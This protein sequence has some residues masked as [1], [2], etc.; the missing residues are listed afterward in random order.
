MLDKKALRR[1]AQANP[2]PAIPAGHGLLHAPQVEH[3]IRS[4]VRIIGH[5]RTLVLYVY[6]REQA[7]QGD[8][9]PLWTMFHAKDGYIT[10]A[11]NP[12]GTTKWRTATFEHLK[13]DYCFVDK[14][15]FYSAKD[16]ERVSRYFNSDSPGFAS[17]VRAQSKLLDRRLEKR[18]RERDRKVRARM[19]GLPAL[20]RDLGDWLRRAVLPA[21]FLYAHAKGG[22]ATGVCSSCGQE[23]SLTGVKHNA[24]GVCPHCGRE[25]TMKVRG[26]MGRLCDRETCQVVQ[27]TGPDELVIRIIK[28]TSNVSEI[29]IW[30]NARQF[31]SVDPDGR[32]QCDSYYDCCDS[33][34]PHWK[35]GER[36]VFYPYSYNFY[37]DTCGHVYCR[38]LQKN[39]SGTPWQYCPLQSFYE[40]FREPMQ[41][42]PFLSAHLKHPKLEHL[43]KVGFYHLASDLVYRG[44]HG[45]TLDETQ[46]RT[47]R[48]LGVGAEDV[49]F[50]RNLDVDMDT[51]KIFQGYCQC[52]LKDRQQLLNWQLERK[53][54]YNIEAILEHMTAHK[55]M[56][57]LDEQ[58]AFL[59]FRLTQ[60]KAQRYRSMQDLVTEYG[61]YLDMCEKQHYDM[62]NS[63]VLYPKDLQKA[64]DKVARRIQLKA[65]AKMRKDFRTT[66]QR[67]MGQLDFEF[68]GMKIV[69]PAAP[70]DIVAEGHA[71]HHCVGGYVDRVARQKCMILFLRRCEDVAKPFYTVEVR[72]QKA[73]QVRGMQN[74]DMTPEVK[75]FMDRWERQVL[76]APA[77]A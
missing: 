13:D 5:R 57:Y 69:Y 28:V 32:A 39:L 63:F 45:S 38:N 26:R 34:H 16:Q 75:R 27:K 71:L 11:R 54:S 62:S 30:E 17:L 40:H 2:A 55:L 37:A 15:A 72:N 61:D 64:H 10:L 58:Y 36:P 65:D 31:V 29:K 12:D 21:Y 67:I 52:N 20:P 60:H 74:A 77:A 25:I 22:E 4:A 8:C 33:E 70:D 76:R 24:K 42:Y 46:N 48:L 56:R 49:D 35:K 7:A 66:Y 41:L 44:P 73:V 1:F 43:V 19:K 47:H 18:L 59:Q 68:G 14:C 23:A 6:T 53:V 9:Q 51:L 50:L 3:I